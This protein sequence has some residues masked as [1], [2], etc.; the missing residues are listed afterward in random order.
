MHL[1][2]LQT[3]C[4]EGCTSQILSVVDLSWVALLRRSTR[5]SWNM[6]NS[7]I[8]FFS[9][10][11]CF[12]GY[13]IKYHILGEKFMTDF[14][15]PSPTWVICIFCLFIF[16]FFCVLEEKSKNLLKCL[17]MPFNSMYDIKW[18]VWFSTLNT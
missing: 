6:Q 18:V 9:F 15:F 14:F 17:Q 12:L 10:K 2:C 7:C 16:C 13:R 5:S 8:I 4:T 3:S 1:H 11:Q